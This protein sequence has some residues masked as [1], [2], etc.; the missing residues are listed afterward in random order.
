MAKDLDQRLS[1]IQDKVEEVSDT[2]HNID[3]ELAVHKTTFNDHL[4]TDEQMY[5]EFVRMNDILMT[6][7]ESLKEHMHRTSIAENRQQ[8][9]EDLVKSIDARL[10]PFETHRLEDEAVKKYRNDKLKKI[11]KY[12]TIIATIVGIIVAL[13]SL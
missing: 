4:K 13:K 2:V 5:K 1:Y 7:T 11:G 3:K 9:L 6:N 8:I 10:S 12:V